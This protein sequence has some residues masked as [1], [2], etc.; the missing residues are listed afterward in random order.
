MEAISHGFNAAVITDHDSILLDPPEFTEESIFQELK[1][2]RTEILYDYTGVPYT[3]THMSNPWHTALKP[4]MA[5]GGMFLNYSNWPTM[6][7]L[8]V[9][10]FFGYIEGGFFSTGILNFRLKGHGKSKERNP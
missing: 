7:W 10:L 1:M 8:A 2:R 9:G 6:D 4:M 5:I 3:A